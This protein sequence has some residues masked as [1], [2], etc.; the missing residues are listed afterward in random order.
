MLEVVSKPSTGPRIKAIKKPRGVLNLNGLNEEAV[1]VKLRLTGVR[2]PFWKSSYWFRQ[3]DCVFL[4]YEGS[5]GPPGAPTMAVE[6]RGP[7]ASCELMGMVFDE[8]QQGGQPN[9]KF[10]I[11]LFS[12]PYLF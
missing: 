2:A 7:S 11:H 6:F 1:K 4:H 12:I 8:R 9:A 5:S 3:S 10:K